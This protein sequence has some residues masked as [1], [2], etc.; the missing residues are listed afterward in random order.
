[1]TAL[2]SL[3]CAWTVDGTPVTDMSDTSRLGAEVPA[4]AEAE[5][6]AGSACVEIGADADAPASRSSRRVRGGSL[7]AMSLVAAYRYCFS[8]AGRPAG[9]WERSGL[10]RRGA[11]LTDTRRSPTRT[12]LARPWV[13]T[14]SAWMVVM[15]AAKDVDEDEEEDDEE[16][17]EEEEAEAGDWLSGR[18]A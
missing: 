8:V 15:V 12:L 13:V 2:S 18:T 4:E 5:T 14:T 3:M 7:S 10:L 6:A 1:M 17:E 9:V 11:S 16:D